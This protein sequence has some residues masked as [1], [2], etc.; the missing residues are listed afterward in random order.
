MQMKKVSL[1]ILFLLMSNLLFLTYSVKNVDASGTIYIRQD[2]SIDPPT[3]PIMRNGDLYTV[4]D[5]IISDMDGIVIQKDNVILDGASQII[6]GTD[7]YSYFSG[8]SII[9]RIN[10]TI[11]RMILKGFYVAILLRDSSYSNISQ[12]ELSGN[13][14]GIGLEG[15]YRYPRL[16]RR[17][18]ITGNNATAGW[19]GIELYRTSEN[20]L[21]N[22]TMSGNTFNFCV[23]GED[24]A[25]FHNDVDTSNTVDRK[26]I[27]YWINAKDAYIPTDAGFVVLV[28]SVNITVKGLDLSNNFCGIV[29]ERTTQS[30][31]TNNTI[32]NHFNGVYLRESSKNKICGNDISRNLCGV[33]L[34]MHSSEN[35]VRNN[36]IAE[37]EYDGIF[38]LVDASDNTILGNTIGPGG[39]L[40]MCIG[41]R[42]EGQSN[43]NKI[44]HN[45]IIS[46]PMQTRIS[47]SVCYWDD[48][49][50]SGGNYWSDHHGTDLLNGQ[51]QNITGEDG[52]ADTPLVLNSDVDHYP[53]MSLWTPPDIAVTD[54]AISETEIKQGN[55]AALNATFE[56]RGNKIEAF[57]LT[58]YANSTAIRSE[59]VMLAMSNCT[60]SFEWNTTSLTPG[61]YIIS[62]YVQPLPEEVETSNNNDTY[63]SLIHLFGLG[64]INNDGTVN[65]KDVMIAI[66]AFNSF[67]DTARWNPNADIDS[68]GH[69][70][71]RDILLIVLHFNNR[72]G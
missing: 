53:L 65:M 69:I 7:R 20:T 68:N 24:L 26:P 13:S 5:T 51:Y 59:Q 49:Y 55:T 33:F 8:I 71:M 11:M 61:N 54:L 1:T 70:D 23:D 19:I 10:V 72:A 3:A 57:D 66:L 30:T 64:D 39:Q 58:I 29:L 16:T 52:I 28:N 42:I 15:S 40:N 43:R 4:S 31:I 62:A 48:E 41:V 36:T 2:G 21:K 18:T 35:I 38:L 46:N 32:K 17:N 34:Y 12:N 45:N 9:E 37:S 27:S 63:E 67:P 56:N 44:Y 47:E 6:Q 14:V 60:L 22:N 25:D 50:P